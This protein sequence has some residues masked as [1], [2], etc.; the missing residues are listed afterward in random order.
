MDKKVLLIDTMHPLFSELL[1]KE[2][3][4]IVDGTQFSK[5][6]VLSVLDQ[7]Q[8]VALRSRILFDQA[9]INAAKNL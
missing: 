1:I 2:G 6:E 3:F 5:E 9:C 8:G 4:L 7:F